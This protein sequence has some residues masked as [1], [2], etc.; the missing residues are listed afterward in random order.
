M[1]KYHVLFNNIW[2]MPQLRLGAIGLTPK[3]VAYLRAL[4][5]LFAN[6]DKLGWTFSEQLPFD[7]VVTDSAGRTGNPEWFA[8]FDGLVLTLVEPPGRPDEDTVAYPVH[9]EQFRTWLGLRHQNTAKQGVRLAPATP[10]SAAA[11]PVSEPAGEPVREVAREAAQQ[12]VQ[13]AAQPAVR[14][15]A[16]G[17]APEAVRAAP[18]TAAPAARTR[19]GQRRFKLRRWP[20]TAVL[21]DNPLHLKIATLMVRNA[22]GTEL[23]AVLTGRPEAECRRFVDTLHRAGLLVEHAAHAELADL[24]EPAAVESDRASTAAPA[25]PARTGLLASLRRH[26]GM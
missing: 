9:A 23:L 20:S 2:T 18:P 3:D 24:A 8:A 17:P 12:A 26:L 7:A 5:R 6:T 1:R 21:Q 19:P 14:Q 22:I 15:V 25:A 10:A 16:P 4:V 11:T 13:E